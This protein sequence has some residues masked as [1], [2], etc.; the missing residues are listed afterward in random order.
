M[1]TFIRFSGRLNIFPLIYSNFHALFR[2]WNVS[3]LLSS[4]YKIHARKRNHRSRDISILSALRASSYRRTRVCI[5]FGYNVCASR[6]HTIDRGWI[7]EKERER[8][9]KEVEKRR[10]NDG[11]RAKK[12]DGERQEIQ[13]IRPGRMKFLFFS[14]HFSFSAFREC[15]ILRTKEEKTEG[16]RNLAMSLFISRTSTSKWDLFSANLEVPT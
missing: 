6:I 5:L 4:R 7:R 10:G 11:G 9:K 8:K 16:I 1:G 14:F 2:D 13:G 3:E 12:R 15:D